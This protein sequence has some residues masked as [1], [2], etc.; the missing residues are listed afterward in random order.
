VVVDEVA[1]MT[2]MGQQ[3]GNQRSSV[4]PAARLRVGVAAPA[5]RAGALP[6][7]RP[8]KS[9]WPPLFCLL[10]L[11][12]GTETVLVGAFSRYFSLAPQRPLIQLLSDRH[13]FT[14]CSEARLRL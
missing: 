5:I 11:L 12:T 3:D 8:T 10:H 13:F 4:W 9:V 6:R 1:V 2:I 14:I 7:A